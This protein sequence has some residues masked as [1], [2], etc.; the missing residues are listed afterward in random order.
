M[1]GAKGPEG[2]GGM[3]SKLTEQWQKLK[4][5]VRGSGGKEE[6][7]TNETGTTQTTS[8]GQGKSEH[9]RFE[10]LKGRAHDVYEKAKDELGDKYSSSVDRLTKMKSKVNE[11]IKNEVIQPVTAKVSSTISRVKEFKQDKSG[12]VARPPENVQT[13]S[14]SVPSHV[15]SDQIGVFRLMQ[16]LKDSGI[17]DEKKQGILGAF[18]QAETPEHFHE[19]FEDSNN[20]EHKDLFLNSFG[21]VVYNSLVSGKEPKPLP[22]PLPKT[23]NN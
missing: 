14:P 9:R 5:H 2:G 12:S 3:F 13:Q 21:S 16:Q 7:V 18:K 6:N 4:G 23:E 15:K 1:E 10:G 20:K 22:T 8:V 17:S 11:R 19:Y